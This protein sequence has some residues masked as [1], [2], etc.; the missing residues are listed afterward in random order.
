MKN[1]HIHPRL[2]RY[3][4]TEHHLL[5]HF[6]NV[7]TLNGM[8]TAIS[9]NRKCRTQPTAALPTLAPPIKEKAIQKA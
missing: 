3:S 9:T 5:F 7:D 1:A 6:E 4:N 8:A 2:Q